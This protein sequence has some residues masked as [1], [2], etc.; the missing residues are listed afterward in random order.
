[1]TDTLA[2]GPY[3]DRDATA[4]REDFGARLLARP[5]EIDTLTETERAGIR[6]LAYAGGTP[7]GAAEMDKLPGLKVIANFGVG[8]DAID[9]AAASARGIK[10]TNTP[11]VLNDD[12]ADLAVGLL[13]ALNRRFEPGAAS[14]RSGDWAAKGDLPLGRKMSGRR[15]GVL[16]MGRIGREIADRLAAFKSEIH[17]QSRSPKDAPA[18][19][20]YHADPVELAGAV[21]DL[22]IAIVGGPATQGLVNAEV[23]KALGPDGV[24]VNISRGSVIDE[25]ALIAALTDGTIRGAALDVFRG[26]PKVDQRLVKLDNLYPLPH[27]GSATVETRGAMGDLQRR[28]LRA[29][30]DGTALSTP[31]N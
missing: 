15:I 6:G 16:G 19:W 20:T 7:F 9:V 11:D 22:V 27:I 2:I 28:N 3:L 26:E 23:L 4:L 14:I 25:D 12:V 10:V 29:G 5:D 30:L 1:M 17:Y 8:Y 18:G 31:V 13:I 21:D 24:V